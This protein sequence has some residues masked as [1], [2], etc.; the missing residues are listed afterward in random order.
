MNKELKVEVRHLRLEDY[1]DLRSAMEK[2]YPDSTDD[3]WEKKDI[4]RLLKVFPEGQ[5]CV[6]VNDK[7]V[8]LALS[9]IV[10]YSKFS[11]NHT[12]NQITA[13][14]TFTTHDP[15][16]DVLYG[17]EMFVHPEYRGM[18]LGRR[19]Y[20][21]R[22]ELCE[23]LNL[24]AVI[25]GGRI[26][27]YGKYADEMTPR[28][29]INK[30]SDKEIYD[31]TLTFQLSN[32]FHVKKI[33]K[34]Y[35][36]D[37]EESKEYATLLEWNNIYYQE[38][39]TLINAPQ[40][41]VRLGLV[42]WQM[43]HFPAFDNLIEQSEFFI[44][45]VSGYQADFILFPEFFNAP[46]MAKYNHL[47]E[48]E[49][50]R[51]LAAY[52]EEL[53]R[54]FVEF[55]ISYNVNIITGSMPYLEEGKLYNISYLCRRDGSWDSFKKIHI[56]PN[57][58]ET[59]GM[60]GGDEIRVF[61]TD[62]GKVGIAICYDV[63]FPELIRIYAE[64]GLQIL[65]VPFLTDTQNGYSR[66]RRCSQARAIENECYVALAGCVGNL[67]R[68]NN[69][70]IQYAQSAVFT[71]SDFAFPTNAIKSEATPNTEM[72]LIVDVDLNL[73]KD[74]HHNGTVRTMQDRRS[75]LYE[76]KWKRPGKLK[77]T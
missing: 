41:V 62:S 39:E 42:Q 56:T 25:A 57:E 37:D 2:A 64:Q 23:N 61:D 68:V 24:R 67:P 46:L 18:R 51:K 1:L 11:D 28:Q 71:P 12:Y 15:D 72:T 63:E 29:Y 77:K 32:N 26:P 44:D 17:I 10:D 13:H 65:F 58:I 38:K 4:R 30:V 49:A 55:S 5:L 74:L 22:K 48:A 6:A 35:L 21:V 70:D 36:P 27:N 34:N 8:A 66:V 20:D 75:D 53:R 33:L 69:M 19:L 50:I 60:S 54:R 47:G 40:P 3:Y 7:V 76:I 16:G 9:I 31:P 14:E 59:W 45:A 52:T 73:L 43:R